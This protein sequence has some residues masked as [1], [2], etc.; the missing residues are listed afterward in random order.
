MHVPIARAMGV[1][2]T[3]ALAA[4]LMAAAQTAPAPKAERTRTQG[5][6]ETDRF[7]KAGNN[8]HASI[9]NARH[10]TKNTLDRYNK[11]VT[12][13]STNMKGD[14]KKLMGAADDMKEEIADARL[15]ITN[16]KAA[17]ETYFTGR[18]T[19]NKGIQDQALQKA[20]ADRL[21]ASR[22]DLDTVL[23]GLTAAGDSLE[24]FRKDLADQIT[25]LGSDLTPTAM[26]ALKPAAEKLNKQGDDALSKIDAANAALRTYLDGLKAPAS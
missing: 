3:A 2:L 23:A 4:P 5:L 19:T 20:A 21:A 26:T 10:E 15:E 6:K 25:F 9:A 13:P 24:A 18:E 16:M 17:G 11:L 1:L 12:Q 7:V 14:Y 8:A 22:K